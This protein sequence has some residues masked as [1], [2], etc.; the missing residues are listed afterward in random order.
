[1]SLL[2]IK[3]PA[4]YVASR[5]VAYANDAGHAVNVSDTAPLP[6]R[7]SLTQTTSTPLSGSMSGSGDTGSFTPELGRTIWISLS[8]EWNGTAALLRS[9]DGGANWLPLT[10]GGVAYGRF[11]GNANE[12]VI[13]EGDAA[14]IYCLRVAL[15]SGT[16]AYRVAQ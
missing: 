15:L 3:E 16:L 7:A 6:V 12:P 4:R 9:V 1:M 11:S 5:A 8:G 2:P 10:I 14:A 13:E